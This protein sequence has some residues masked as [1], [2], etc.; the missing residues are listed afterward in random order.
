MFYNHNPSDQILLQNSFLK[1]KFNNK[2]KTNSPFLLQIE[3]DLLG[4]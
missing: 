2:L 3:Y 1:I 4:Y